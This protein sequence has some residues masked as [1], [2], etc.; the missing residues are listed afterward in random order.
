MSNHVLFRLFVLC[1]HSRRLNIIF[2]LL[3]VKRKVGSLDYQQLTPFE[4]VKKIR[5]S[6]FVS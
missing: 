1:L 4:G 3:A 6:D 5:A 2:T